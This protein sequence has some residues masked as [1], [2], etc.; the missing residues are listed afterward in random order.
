MKLSPAIL[1]ALAKVDA[2]HVEFFAV[3]DREARRRPRP[4]LAEKEVTCRLCGTP[5]R[6]GQPRYREP[7]GDVHADGTRHHA[8]A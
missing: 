6:E 2:A 3:L 4:S 1:V 8:P 7:V 5:M